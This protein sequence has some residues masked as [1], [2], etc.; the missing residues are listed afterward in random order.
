M[1]NTKVLGGRRSQKN[2]KRMYVV[3]ITVRIAKEMGRYINL[4]VIP[5]K[6]PRIF[7]S[8]CHGKKKFLRSKV[9]DRLS[10]RTIMIRLKLLKCHIGI[11]IYHQFKKSSRNEMNIS[12]YEFTFVSF[13]SC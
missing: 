1:I 7:L 13:S 4:D 8:L 2:M 6:Y 10:S 12:K 5:T 9:N 11:C 3:V